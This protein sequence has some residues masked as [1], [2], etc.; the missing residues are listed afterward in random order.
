VTDLMDGKELP[1]QIITSE[2]VFP[3]ETAK[4]FMSERKY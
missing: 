3:R 1:S 2:S 4:Q